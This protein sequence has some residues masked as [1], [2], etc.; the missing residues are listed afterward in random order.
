MLVALLPGSGGADTHVVAGFATVY[1]FYAFPHGT[2]LRLSQ[3]LVPTPLQRRGVATTLLQAVRAVAVSSGA[4]DVTV[5]DPTDALQKL[6]VRAL[7]HRLMYVLYS[8]DA[9]SVADRVLRGTTVQEVADLRA[10]RGI[11]EV[12]GAAR[13]AVAGAQAAS[14]AEARQASL[15]CPAA[16]AAQLRERLRLCKPQIRIVWEALLFLA[17]RVRVA[18]C[19]LPCIHH[20]HKEVLMLIA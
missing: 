11:A 3:I 4:V 18:P 12:A 7:S 13:A 14:T 8:Q 1:K 2:R 6:R 20:I 17:A 9:D 10:A 16:V 15:E 5:E 19:D